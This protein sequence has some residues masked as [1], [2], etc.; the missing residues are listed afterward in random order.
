MP[1]IVWLV[2]T[3]AYPGELV[4][5]GICGFVYTFVAMWAAPLG[6]WRRYRV[7][8]GL[9]LIAAVAVGFAALLP[10]LRAEHAN[11]LFRVQEPTAVVRAGESFAPRDLLGLFLNNFAWT[12]DGTVTAWAVGVPIL[13]GLAAVR[14][15]AL[16]RQ[17]PLIAVGIVA[18][19]LAV[20]P[21]IGFVGH[22]MTSL[23][24]LFPSRFP[25][26]DYKSVVAVTFVILAADA[27]SGVAARRSGLA[28]RAGIM[29]LLLIVAA[30][31]A[32]STYGSPTRALWL[33]VVVVFACALL[34]IIRVSPRILVAAL[35]LLVVVDGGREIYDYRL[36]NRISPWRSS[37]AD[38]APYRARDGTIRKLGRLLNEA[39]SNRPARTPPAAP[40]TSDPTG[41]DP[42]AQ[43]WIAAGYHLND[44]G[45]TSMKVLWQAEHSPTFLAMLL[46]PWS[47]YA[48]S[49]ATVQCDGQAVRLPP[50]AQWQ[51]SAG[52]RTVAYKREQILYAVNLKQ[53]SLLV[54]NELAIPGWRVNSSRV[55]PV[56]A[57]VPLRVWRL[58]AGRY[59]FAASYHEPDR[60]GQELAALLAVAA[61]V[62]CAAVL[63]RRRMPASG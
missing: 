53:P 29:G 58:A 60:T 26:A 41:T 47:G 59:T 22:A 48:F 62:A 57:H 27:W 10:Y 12:Y 7:A 8:L 56:D 42:D 20:T 4:S 52:I 33:V 21:K 25:A 50:P 18:L 32:P 63:Y 43:G 40:L 23:R 17:A 3:G 34:T 15:T 14:L 39:P 49:C 55:K 19:A 61:W 13:V 51:P 2:A 44:Y 38:S 36:L 30:V 16:R 54:E 45:G 5:F 46:G 31:L 6:T 37:P 28:W 24:P 35:V 1:P 9:A 11:E